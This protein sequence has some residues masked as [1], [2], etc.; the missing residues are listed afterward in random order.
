MQITKEQLTEFLGSEKVALAYLDPINTY[1]PKYCIIQP[2]EVKSFLAHTAHES[3][4]FTKLRENTNYTKAE[5]LIEIFPKYFNQKNVKAYVGN[6]EAIANRVYANRMGNGSEDSGDG[7][8]YRGIGLMQHTGKD[9]FTI[10][11]ARIKKIPSYYILTPEEL[12]KPADAVEAACWFWDFKQLSN[13]CHNLTINE[14]I[15]PVCGTSPK[16]SHLIVDRSLFEKQTIRVNG[17][18]NGYESRKAWLLK[19]DRIFK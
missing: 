10:L 11:G 12:L 3:E 4:G 5:R 1:L 18:L 9:Q 6:P 15:T 7:Y 19:A 13:Y 2:I 8:R 16:N 14:F 17:G